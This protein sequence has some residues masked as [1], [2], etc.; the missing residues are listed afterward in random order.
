MSPPIPKRAFRVVRVL[1]DGT[2]V[3]DVSREGIVVRDVATEES[4]RTFG[5]GP[6]PEHPFVLSPDHGLLLTGDLDGD[7][8][9]WDVPA[10][11]F[12]RT[13]PGNGSRVLSCSFDRTNGIVVT[14]S[15]DGSVVVWNARTGDRLGAIP[16]AVPGAHAVSVSPNARYLL[17]WRRSQRGPGRNET[18]GRTA[19]LWSLPRASSIGGPPGDVVAGCVWREDSARLYTGAWSNQRR[20]VKI[21]EPDTFSRLRQS[22]SAGVWVRPVTYA[23]GSGLVGGASLSSARTDTAYGGRYLPFDDEHGIYHVAMSGD[24]STLATIATDGSID[25]WRSGERVR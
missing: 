10:G 16:T 8:H 23:P 21:W 24:G 5:R 3:L 20:S 25:I 19:Q 4:I 18:I 1:D 6:E 7:A 12:L 22:P 14:G 17:T 11:A 2:R 15:E 9:L 13:L